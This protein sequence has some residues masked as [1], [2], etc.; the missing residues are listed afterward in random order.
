MQHWHRRTREVT[1]MG[2]SV[3]WTWRIQG[4]AVTVGRLCEW[5]FPGSTPAM[6]MHSLGGPRLGWGS[7]DRGQCIHRQHKQPTQASQGCCSALCFTGLLALW[8]PDLWSLSYL[9]SRLPA[10]QLKVFWQFSCEIC[11][12][13]LIK[14]CVIR[15]RGQPGKGTHPSACF[16]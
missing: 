7:R 5:E 4:I 6:F 2:G 8:A 12:N 16:M 11:L 10:H 3:R 14:Q 9:S 13:Y 15:W 1:G